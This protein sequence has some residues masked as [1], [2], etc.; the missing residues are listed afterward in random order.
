MRISRALPVAAALVAAA[1]LAAAAPRA[2]ASAPTPDVYGG[3]SY[4]HAGEASLNGWALAGSYPLQGRLRLV[5]DLTGHYGS[6]AGSDLSQT[7]L[8]AGVRNVWTRKGLSPFVEGLMGL[9][10]TSVDA[11]DG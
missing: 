11:S 3:Y 6:F 5:L 1:T 7:A 10:R 9:A 4:T 8:L 2:T